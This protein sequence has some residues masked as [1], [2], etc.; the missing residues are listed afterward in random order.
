MLKFGE[1][2]LML[3]TAYEDHERPAVPEPARVRGH[4][5]T[6]LYFS[7]S[8]PDPDAV[9]VHLRRKGWSLSS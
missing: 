6:S 4:G 3:N 1:A 9:C 8:S 5:D 2:T 7:F